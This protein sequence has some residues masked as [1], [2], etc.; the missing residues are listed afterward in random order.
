LTEKQNE[1][2]E[3]ALENH[4]GYTAGPGDYEISGNI[5]KKTF[6]QAAKIGFLNSDKRFKQKL[7][8]TEINDLIQK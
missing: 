3:K 6:H 7:H 2:L 5:N 8:Q 4:R 1:I